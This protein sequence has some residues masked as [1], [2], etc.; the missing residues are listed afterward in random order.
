MDGN[1]MRQKI[2]ALIAEYGIEQANAQEAERTELGKDYDMNCYGA[3]FSA[4]EQAACNR[5]A[6]MVADLI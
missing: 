4:G 6:E 1:T 2:L 5:L 3:G